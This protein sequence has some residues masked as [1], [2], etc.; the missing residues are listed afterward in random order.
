MNNGVHEQY[1]QQ[2]KE[3]LAPYENKVEYYRMYSTEAA[4]QMAHASLDFAYIDARHDYC[5]VAE[6]LAA[7]WPLLK[8]GG[9]MAGHDFNS[10][11]EVRGQDWSLCQDGRIFPQAVKGAV[12]DFA[13]PRGLTVSVTYQERNFFTWMIQKPM[14]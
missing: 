8:P 3:R 5:G 9:I 13:L 1:L 6:D 7:Y 2:T 12:L 14:C 10:N 4:K 11:D